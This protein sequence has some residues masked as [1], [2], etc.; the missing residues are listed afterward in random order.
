[1][2]RYLIWIFDAPNVVCTNM[3]VV[4]P[5]AQCSEDANILA[6]LQ[7]ALRLGCGRVVV[8]LHLNAGRAIIHVVNLEH[9]LHLNSLQSCHKREHGNFA[10]ID[11]Q[12]RIWASSLV[13][14]LL[15]LVCIKEHPK[16]QRHQRLGISL[17][18]LRLA[19]AGCPCWP[20]SAEVASQTLGLLNW[21]STVATTR[22]SSIA[23]TAARNSIEAT[24][25]LVASDIVAHVIERTTG[26][27]I[28]SCEAACATKL[29][30][31]S[32]HGRSCAPVCDG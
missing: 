25:S 10:A 4:V 2:E 21:R 27:T 17:A 26:T 3:K 20:R 8:L 1:M 23:T 16:R 5:G 22:S 18:L 15:S 6:G 19:F 31:A 9:L 24:A 13:S 7:L 12:W 28:P 30:T 32:K 11:D 14:L 29:A